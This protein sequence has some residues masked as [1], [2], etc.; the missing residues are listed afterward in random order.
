MTCENKFVSPLATQVA[1]RSTA[2][3]RRKPWG[4]LFHTTGRGIPSS[5]AKKGLST[6]AVA[7]AWYRR[8]QDGV[9][10]YSWGGPTYVLGHA[11]D[12][13]Q[14]AEENILTNHAGG[15]DRDRYNSGEWTSLLS[16]EMVARW[17]GQWP[18]RQAPQR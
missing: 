1:H 12:L 16:P 8:S 5:A 14:I 3:A 10:G 9:N 17:R 2:I 4:L 11:G 15:P 7:L 18:G 13:Y 6:V